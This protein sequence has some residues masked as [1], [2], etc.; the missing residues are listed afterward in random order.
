MEKAALLLEN[1][2]RGHL[3]DVCRPAGGLFAHPFLDPGSIYHA[4]LWDWDSFWT[5]YGILTTAGPDPVF[6]EHARGNVLNFLSVQA[7]DGYI[8]MYLSREPEFGDYLLRRHRAGKPANM[9]K[10]FLCQQALLISLATDDVSWIRPHLMSLEKYLNYARETYYHEA[11]GLY[12]FA[13]DVMIGMDNDPA[14]FGRPPYSTASMFLNGFMYGELLA[15]GRLVG[16]CSGDAKPWQDQAHAL[17]AAMA[18]E[19]WDPR[20]RFYYSVDTDVRTR[21]YDWFHKGL[22]VFW[23]TLPIRI[24]TWT[25]FIPMLYGMAATPQAAQ[26]RSVLMD[27]NIFLG[28]CGV[29]TLDR[30]E[31][32]YNLEATSNPSNWLG[33][34]WMVSNYVA[35]RG[36]LNYGFDD[37]ARQI[38]EKSLNLLARDIEKT[39]TLHEYYHPE[40]GEPIVNADFLNWNMLALSMYRELEGDP[41]LLPFA[42][43]DQG[44]YPC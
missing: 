31:R 33:P 26:L 14:V 40:T 37:D 9:H 25:G 29:R 3:A 5:V 21:G 12:R 11:S 42:E 28:S 18:R 15:M 6:M 36:L 34:V 43:L 22:G 39:G 23:H 2:I 17:S 41:P 30:N 44:D 16:M 19:C 13:D 20:D 7:P 1:Y 27:P 4:N 10:P 38:A 35:F 24:R 32:M 8:P